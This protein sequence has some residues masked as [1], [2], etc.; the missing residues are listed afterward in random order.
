MDNLAVGREDDHPALVLNTGHIVF[1]DLPAGMGDRDYAARVQR[2]HMF[3]GHADNH[4]VY[5]ITGHRTGLVD[6]LHDRLSRAVDIDHDTLADTTGQT[7]ANPGNSQPPRLL[8][9]RN[10]RT[11][12]GRSNI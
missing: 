5:L 7:I 2:R 3:P 11:H 6:T 4:P 12:F 9:L 10:H 1:R 8:D